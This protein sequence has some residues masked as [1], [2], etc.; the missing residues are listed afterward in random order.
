MN[1][2]LPQED[3]GVAESKSFLI[4]SGD[5]KQTMVQTY[6]CLTFSS[7][8]NSK[9]FQM[10]AS[11][12]DSKV[13]FLSYDCRKKQSV[14]ISEKDPVN[15]LTPSQK[16]RAKFITSSFNQLHAGDTECFW[17]FCAAKIQA[18]FKMSVTKR[19]F[20][21]HI[22]PMYHIAAIQIQ[23]AFWGFLQWK[24]NKLDPAT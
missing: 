8:Q 24:Q 10:K 3:K 2:L 6:G 13:S 14:K 7:Y 9:I 18:L 19:L 5:Y 12:Q 1:S 20:K 15:E 11:A 17:N 23:W 16:L 22:F 4:L 21:F